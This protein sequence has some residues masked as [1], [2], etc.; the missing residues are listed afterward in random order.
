MN[1]ILNKQCPM[2][3]FDVLVKWE[4]EVIILESLIQCSRLVGTIKCKL[5]NKCFRIDFA[6]INNQNWR[7]TIILTG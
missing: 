4:W 7:Y 6:P 3:Q 2:H 1:L 5:H